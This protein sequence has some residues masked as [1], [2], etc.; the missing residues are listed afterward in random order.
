MARAGRFDEARELGRTIGNHVLGKVASLEAEAGQ[1]ADALTTVSASSIDEFITQLA[2]W[3]PQLEQ[4]EPELS[5]AMISSAMD[6]A[7]WVQPDWARAR[8]VLKV[9]NGEA[10]QGAPESN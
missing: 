1:I 8:M 4:I 3:A 6:V 9:G 7:A 10:Q 5:V 2:N